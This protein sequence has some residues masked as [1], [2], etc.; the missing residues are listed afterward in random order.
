[1]DAKTCNGK[2]RCAAAG[3][4]FGAG[5]LR[6]S[7]L[8]RGIAAAAETGAS[9]ILGEARRTISEIAPTSMD[10]PTK[11]MNGANAIK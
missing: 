9:L 6:I 11:T 10:T 5:K 2:G 1:L 3:L 8:R 7:A 4:A